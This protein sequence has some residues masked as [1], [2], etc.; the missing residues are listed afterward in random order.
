MRRRAD[1]Q[2]QDMDEQQRQ[3]FERAVD[4][5]KQAS[6]EASRHVEHNPETDSATAGD[7]ASD[8]ASSPRQKNRGKGKKT[9]DKWNQ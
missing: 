8:D 3:A 9:A 7:R 2:F 5:K 4:V 1:G 6:D